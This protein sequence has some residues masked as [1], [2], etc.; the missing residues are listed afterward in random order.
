[1]L[2]PVSAAAAR[3]P[4]GSNEPTLNQRI[5]FAIA[6]GL[7]GAL[8]HFVRAA[9]TGGHSDF[10]TLWYGARMLMGNDNPYLAI[11]PGRQIDLPSVPNYPAPA[12]VAALPF[13][14]FPVHLAG[15]LFVFFSTGLLAFGCTR[16]SWHRVPLFP[17]IAFATTAQLGQSSMFFAAAAFI[18]ALAAFALVKPQASL[19]IAGSA[20]DRS[21]IAWAALGSIVLVLVSFMLMPEW[22]PHWTSVLRATDHFTSPIVRF[23][24][25]AIALVLL[26][27]RR[28]EAWLVFLAACTPQ[29]WY[30][31]NSLILLL[32]AMTYREACVLSLVSSAGWIIAALTSGSDTR[33]AETREIMGAMLVAACYLPATIAVL[34]RAND[35]VLPFWIRCLLRNVPHGYRPAR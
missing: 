22:V 20:V 35:G 11:G 2:S 28:P 4:W 14:L 12:F 1:M 19:P 18:P 8:M 32:V 3:V 5:V 31:Y 6:V 7:L 24:G 16:D 13:A 17:S 26:R 23:G 15:T 29:T 34:R 30:P 10:S 33:S 9:E 25:P 21:T 27:W